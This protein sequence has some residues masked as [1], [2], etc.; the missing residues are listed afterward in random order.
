MGTSLA[1]YGFT[2][3]IG[4]HPRSLRR[5]LQLRDPAILGRPYA[6]RRADRRRPLR[7]RHPGHPRRGGLARRPPDGRCAR[8]GRRGGR[9]RADRRRRGR[10]APSPGGRPGLRRR[11]PLPHRHVCCG[12]RCLDVQ[13]RCRQLRCLRHGLRGRVRPA[14]PERA[15]RHGQRAPPTAARAAACARPSTR[16]PRAPPAQCGRRRL[17]DGL[18]RLRQPSPPT[19]ARPTPATD[20]SHCGACNRACTAGTNA[21]AALRRRAPA[22]PPAVSSGFAD[23]DNNPANGCEANTVT[24][25]TVR[26]LRQHVPALHQRDA[27][28]C[29]QGACG[30]TCRT[31]FGDCDGDARNG[32]EVNTP[33]ERRELRRLRRE[34]AR[35]PT[36]SA[37]LHESSTCALVCAAGFGDC[38]SDPATAASAPSPPTTPTAAPATAPAPRAPSARNGT[39][40]VAVRRGHHLLQRRLRQPPAPDAAHC[41]ACGRVCP[42]PPTARR[43][44]SGACGRRR[45]ATRASATATATPPTAARPT[46]TP[47]AQ[48][49]GA[50]A[51]TRAAPRTPRRPATAGVCSVSCAAGFADCDRDVDNGCETSTRTV[52]QLRRLR[53]RVHRRQRDGHLQRRAPARC[54]HCNSGFANCNN[55][56]ADGCEVN[57]TNDNANCGACGRDLRARA[58]RARAACAAAS[59]PRGSR[60]AAG[61]AS[62]CRATAHELR[63]LRSG[64][65]HVAAVPHLQ[66]RGVQ[67]PAAEPTTCARARR[68]STWRRA[69]ASTLSAST[70]VRQPRPRRALL[71]ASA[72]ADVFYRFTLTRREYVYADT[73]GASWDTKLFFATSSC[74]D[75]ARAQHPRAARLLCN[76]NR[77]NGRARGRQRLAGGGRCS[78]RARTTWCSPCR[79][80]RAARRDDQLRAPADGQRHRLPTLSAGRVIY[81]GVT[82]GTSGLCAARLRRLGAGKQLLLG[83]LPG[84]RGRHHSRAS[85]C[86]RA[87]WDTLLHLSHGSGTGAAAIK[88]AP[89][90]A[91]ARSS[92]CCPPPVPAGAGLHAFSRRRLQLRVGGVLGDRHAPRQSVAHSKKSAPT[93]IDAPITVVRRSSVSR[94]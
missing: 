65:R 16:R 15:S 24:S 94:P 12:G 40:H 90:A 50:S 10:R 39:C 6:H 32:C 13:S 85:T 74:T 20:L 35:A 84:R 22:R 2:S 38:D 31:G 42:T 18:R 67:L 7:R 46:S 34:R 82:A 77:G 27:T 89:P 29:A 54:R 37:R 71:R 30:F 93:R 3:C 36:A 47:A 86:S 41:G 5:G 53:P 48:H 51:A 55:S 11:R 23:C 70:L 76:D 66:P 1:P 26:R 62:T 73:F 45:A 80:D 78:T 60:S 63:G 19:A 28:V 21:R 33:H 87:T 25:P 64:V 9:R 61:A 91:R 52:S 58:R 75:A 79:R 17:H 72:W 83:D 44:A 57:T 56:A 59:A 92:R 4:T 68:R 69:R 8:G 81:S 43:P 49:C 88:T 14:A